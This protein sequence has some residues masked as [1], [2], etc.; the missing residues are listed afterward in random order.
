MT[1]EIEARLQTAVADNVALGASLALVEAGQITFAG[2]YGRT[3]AD[4]TGVAVDTDTLF[5]YGSISKVICATLI[6]RLVEQ[7]LLDLDRPLPDY[8]PR[9]SFS[10]Q[11]YGQRVSLRHVLSHTTGLP[12]AGGYYGPRG[13]GALREVVEAEVPHYA[14]LAAPGTLHLYANTVYC[15]VGYAAEIVT[16]RDYDSLVQELVLDP[17]GMVTTIFAPPLSAAGRIALPHERGEDGLQPITR[18]PVNDAGHPSSF[19][20]G[21]ATDLARLALAHLDEIEVQATRFLAPSTL[22]EMHREHTSRH[23][24]GTAHPLAHISAGY[25]LGIMTGG[26]KGHRV[27]R[28]GG[29]TLSFNCFFDLLPQSRSGFVLLTNAGEEGPL[30]ELVAFLYDQLTGNPSSGIIPLE[31]PPAIDS[32]LEKE[33]WPLYEGVYLNIEWGGLVGV[34]TKGEI[35]VLAQEGSELPLTCIAPGCYYAQAGNGARLPLAFLGE[36]PGAVEH[37]MFAGAP[38]HR[39]GAQWQPAVGSDLDVFAG[40]YRDLY[41]MN[42]EDILHIEVEDNR[43]LLRE[44]EGE[45]MACDSLGNYAFRCDLGYF[46]FENMEEGG[47]PV[48]VWGKATRYVALDAGVS[49]SSKLSA[50]V[51]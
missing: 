22:R 2:G 15:I 41:N 6:V 5:A 13:A 19:A 35:L 30:M 10:D 8:L 1:T 43:L 16:G 32:P 12:A 28:H 18:L 34:R 9:L 4:E 51:V 21:T 44:G 47:A 40:S 36:G 3:A 29:M 27:L 38:Y 33:R 37:L 17:L 48:L 26:Y 46:E 20:Y 42:E 7:G 45:W 25:G 14:F 50:G 49:R 11:T 23:V 39:Y 24:T 31:A